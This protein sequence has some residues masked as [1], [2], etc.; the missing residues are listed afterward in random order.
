MCA[1]RTPHKGPAA[2]EVLA[3]A[4][5]EGEKLVRSRHQKQPESDHPVPF[6]SR[7]EHREHRRLMAI[8]E[9]S[10]T[11]KHRVPE[12]E[13]ES[14]TA[15]LCAHEFRGADDGCGRCSS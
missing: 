4:A 10:A 11:A 1:H 5:R 9:G 14:K 15:L 3:A 6:R 8:G 13:R 2:I 12:I 7:A